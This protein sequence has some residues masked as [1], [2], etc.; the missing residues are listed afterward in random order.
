MEFGESV[1]S[2]KIIQKALHLERPKHVNL[3]DVYIRYQLRLIN[4][5]EF[6]TKKKKMG[7][8]YFCMCRY[9]FTLSHYYIL[10]KQSIP[11]RDSTSY[12]KHQKPSIL[13]IIPKKRRKFSNL[14]EILFI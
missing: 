12:T 6:V 1:R 3:I 11:K 4:L 8:K 2:Y 7:K 14:A 9:F 5:T 13:N 10:C